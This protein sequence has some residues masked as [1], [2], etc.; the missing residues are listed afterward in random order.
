MDCETGQPLAGLVKTRTKEIV[1]RLHIL[2]SGCPAPVPAH[3]GS[4]FILDIAKCFIMI[5]CGPAATYKMAQL[6]IAPTQVEH[7]FLT[8]H[9]FD[10]N[11]DFP[12]FAL[13]R[14]D[15]DNGSAPELKVYGPSPTRRFVERLLGVEGAFF[16]DWYS[17]VKHPASHECHRQRG[18]SLP[19]AAPSIKT[20]DMGPGTVVETE[21]WTATAEQVH[22]VEPWLISLAYRFE[23]TDGNIVFAGHCGDCP[24]L[25]RFASGVDTLVIACTHFGRDRTDAATADVITGTTEV[26]EIANEAGAGR[27]VLTH[28][29]PGFSMPGV[30]EVAVAQVARMFSGHILFPRELQTIE[31]SS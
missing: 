7:L 13:T 26:A 8:H 18:G 23:T 16:D 11:A 24:E 4:V 20:R 19:R 2:G 15:Q 30:K 10:H 6:G 29:S 17:R 12:C 3:Y 14:W 28:V 21:S 1:V 9:H 31:L 22:H 5:D 27:L 25:R